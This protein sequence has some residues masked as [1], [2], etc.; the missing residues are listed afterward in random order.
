MC[1]SRTHSYTRVVIRDR[2]G[3]V[4]KRNR[5]YFF[6]LRVHVTRARARD[7]T[8]QTRYRYAGRTLEKRWRVFCA[9]QRH[10]RAEFFKKKTQVKRKLLY[11][12]MENWFGKKKSILR[13]YGRRELRENLY[14]YT[15]I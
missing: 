3:N 10:R 1:T 2:V 15:C 7:V 11:T 5:H 8:S 12:A 13:V 4:F 6:F 9:P 14:I